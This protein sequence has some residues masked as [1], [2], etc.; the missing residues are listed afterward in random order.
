[1]HIPS[2]NLLDLLFDV[3]PKFSDQV[4]QF[5]WVSS[6]LPIGVPGS[7]SPQGLLL[8]VPARGSP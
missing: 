2:H 1:M 8:L 6:D 4:Q 5:Q 3:Q 7:G